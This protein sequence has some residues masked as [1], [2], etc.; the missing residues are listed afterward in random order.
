MK[1][2]ISLLLS[3][4]MILSVIGA[5]PFAAGALSND[6]FEYVSA[7]GYVTITRYIGNNIS[8][9]IPD[10]IDDCPVHF[11][12]K[13]AF[14]GNTKLKVLV[15]P[16]SVKTIGPNAFNGTSLQKVKYKSTRA[17]WLKIE[18]A[19]GNDALY[20][21][22]RMVYNS[23]SKLSY[24]IKSDQVMI[25]GTD[26]SSEFLTIPETIE[27][28]PVTQILSYAFEDC[29]TI[30][31]YILPDSVTMIGY[32]GFWISNFRSIII[33]S[34]VTYISNDAFEEVDD[35]EEVYYRGTQAQ[36]DAITIERGNEPLLNA[37][38]NLFPDDGNNYNWTDGGTLVAENEYLINDI[39]VV[40]AKPEDTLA[41]ANDGVVYSNV[42]S[43]VE[44]FAVVESISWYNDTDKKWMRDGDVFE[45]GKYYVA[46][47]HLE[48]SQIEMYIFAEPMPRGAATVNGEPAE[49]SYDPE[50]DHSKSLNVS[51]RF[52]CGPLEQEIKAIDI[53]FDIPSASTEKEKAAPSVVSG[54]VEI[55]DYEWNRKFGGFLYDFDKFEQDTFYVLKLWISAKEAN[56]FRLYTRSDTNNA[57]L[58]G[59][60][61]VNLWVNG[62][63]ATKQQWDDKDMK[64]YL[65][66]EYAFYIPM[67]VDDPDKLI[68]EVS[69]D[70]IKE[71]I[72]GEAFSND[73]YQ[74]EKYTVDRVWYHNDTGRDHKEMARGEVFEKDRQYAVRIFLKAVDDY[75][76]AV[77]YNGSYYVTK[78]DGYINGKNADV[79]YDK[80]NTAVYLYKEYGPL[81][82]EETYAAVLLGDVDGSGKVNVFDASYILKGTTGTKGYPD[83]S[84]MAADAAELRLADVDGSGK[85]NVFDAALVLRYTTGDAKAIALGIGKP[86]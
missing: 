66:A 79:Q 7:Y 76:F 6:D 42:D 40:I 22:D 13:S 43:S 35:L 12:G 11:I 48:C 54:E 45:L 51:Y 69:F 37:H 49:I 80:G 60:P 67:Q 61:F 31:T 74:T 26:D 21:E 70:D 83:Y 5:L 85:V 78:V 10:E 86:I 15:I 59:K 62:E 58:I 82:G 39:D 73:S 68:S 23:G 34:G 64:Y 77:E 71:P 38:L 50:S 63:K 1:K 27:G 25:A 29:H 75:V 4:V 9:V 18:I 47:A 84:K 3:F 19:D 14:E 32:G 20:S 16:A 57:N 56:K 53:Q 24:M 81:T 46:Y 33:G 44:R 2:A 28:L 8:A 36:W 72:V 65:Y 55:E 17:D 41:P 52:K 30:K